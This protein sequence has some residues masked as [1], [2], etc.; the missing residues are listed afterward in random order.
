M[1]RAVTT[2]FATLSLEVYYRILPIYGFR[3]ETAPERPP[4]IGP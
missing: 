4:A 3:K 1:G 2:A